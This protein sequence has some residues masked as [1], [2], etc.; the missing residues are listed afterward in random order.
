M[1]D[2]H[3]QPEP[4]QE[5]PAPCG[6]IARDGAL[7]AYRRDS[8]LD[9]SD[10]RDLPCLCSC[11]DDRRAAL[12]AFLGRDLNNPHFVWSAHDIAAP[13]AFGAGF[14][15]TPDF[16]DPRMDVERP[17]PGGPAEPATLDHA[18]CLRIIFDDDAELAERA[19]NDCDD[20][21]A[22]ARPPELVALIDGLAKLIP[23]CGCTYSAW[24]AQYCGDALRYATTGTLTADGRVPRGGPPCECP[25]HPTP[26]AQGDRAVG[27]GE[28]AAP[29]DGPDGEGGGP[30]AGTGGE[31]RRCACPSRDA[32]RCAAIRY[33]VVDHDFEDPG[34][35]T[36]PCTCVCHDEGPD[37]YDP[38]DDGDCD[39]ATTNG[40]HVEPHAF[41]ATDE[42]AAHAACLIC[43]L[44]AAASCHVH[45][46]TDQVCLT[47]DCDGCGACDPD[48][49]PLQGDCLHCGASPDDTD[50]A[51]IGEDGLCD[52]CRAN[53]EDDHVDDG[54][55]DAWECLG[56]GVPG[57]EGSCIP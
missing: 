16:P 26:P 19:D 37:D 18:A 52:D 49:P 25:C 43:G 2:T 31:E 38:S 39:D 45:P 6:C 10:A 21:P 54:D 30:G 41:G 17:G 42:L 1:S 4:D 23:R 7:C 44:R 56:C 27:P 12:T 51:H 20:K 9:W 48:R 15:G 32:E 46:R 55:D 34:A 40:E 36:E 53:D 24:G 3:G 35:D 5:H 14:D 28:G 57:C 8:R 11:H 33:P 50:P 47:A 13:S 22:D 29:A